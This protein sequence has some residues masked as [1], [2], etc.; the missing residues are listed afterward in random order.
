MARPTVAFVL[1]LIGGILIVVFAGLYMFAK[2]WVESILPPE[3][4]PTIPKLTE[5]LGGKEV[6]YILGIVWGILVIIGAALTY[7]GK[8]GNV[9][10]GAVLG[11]IFG[12]LSLLEI[13]GGL[14]IGFILALIGAILGLVWKP[15][16]QLTPA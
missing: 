10:A 4:V 8:P 5:T 12:L 7:T 2:D 3:C 1:L 15:P 11:L 16:A 13:A 14:Y 6:M 9:K